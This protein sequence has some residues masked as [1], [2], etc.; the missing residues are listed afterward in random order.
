MTSLLDPPAPVA[1]VESAVDDRRAQARE[2]LGISGDTDSPPLRPFLKEYGLGYYPIVALGLLGVVDQFQGEAFTILVPDMSRALALSLS[3]ITAVRTVAFMA[4]VFA[5]LPMAALAQTRGRRAILCIATGIAWSLVTL[6]TGFVSGV[7]TLLLVLVLDGLSSGSV[8]TLHTP[9]LV[10]SYPPQA[11]ARVLAGYNAIKTVG[12]VGSP[13][14]VGV[15]AGPLGLTWRGVFLVLGVISTAVSLTA[16]FLKDPGPGTFDTDKLRQLERAAVAPGTSIDELP[17]DADL[18][19]WEILR[20]VLLVPTIRRMATGSLV[21]G[22]L[23]VPF[24]T[25]LSA[26]LDVR[27]E[28]DAG[29]RGFFFAGTAVSSVLCL[30]VFASFAERRFRA[31]PAW[32]TRFAGYGLIAAVACFAV[33]ALVPTFWLM[34]AGFALG[35]GVLTVAGTGLTLV[36]LAVVEARFRPHVSAI[37]GMFTASGAILGVL[38]LGGLDRRFG[39][40]VAIAA[41]MIPAVVAGLLVA[42]AAKLVN[43]DID[44]MIDVV[45]ES[46]DVRIL[47]ESGGRLPMLATKGIDFSYGQLQVLFDVDFT[48]DEGEMVA[49]LGTNGAGKSTLLKVISG[50]GLPSAG[51]VRFRGQDITYLDPPRRVPLGITQIPGGRAVFGPLTVSEN[52][53]TFGYTLG[54]DRKRIDSL[55]DDCFEAFPRLHERRDSS[56]ATLSGGE[57]QM[58]GLSRALMLKPRLLLIDELSLGLAPI[59]VGQLL[60]MVRRINAEGSAVVL[61]EQSVNIALSLVDHAYF[62]EKG[63]MRFDGPSAELLERGDLL[64]AVFLDGADQAGGTPT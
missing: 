29:E 25:Y 21:L 53:R 2:T 36:L 22:I 42:S 49:L 8:A 7:L 4:S 14:L 61:V 44:T 32:V 39:L 51:T 47:H 37:V 18:T 38:F 62:M 26:F 59:I 3:A 63:Q 33:A 52:L 6:S 23:L 40:S 16:I 20:R 13:L 30:L 48:V 34:C 64:R 50:L 9:L 17:T 31:D 12:L 15:L 46:E 58:L 5:P 54:R 57:Q 56:A 10:D 27:W 28:L 24:G 1:E 60:D 11:R 41:L 45:L 19:F 43:R 35:Q 55:I